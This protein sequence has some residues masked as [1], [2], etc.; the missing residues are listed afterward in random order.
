MT[1]IADYRPD[2]DGLRSL[3]VASVL[4]FHLGLPNFGGGFVGVDIFFVISGFLITG[5]I[6]R[7]YEQTGGFDF[8]RFYVRRVRRIFPALFITIFLATL[9][10]TLLFSSEHLQRLGGSIISAMA[11]TSNLY[12]WSEAG[13]FDA[14][15]FV[16]PLLH[17]WSLSIEEQFYLVWPILLIVLLRVKKS[18]QPVVSIILLAAASLLV[19]EVF[20]DGEVDLVNVLH[21]GLAR[22]I[23]DG[24]STIFYL[25]PFRIYE[26]V[27]GGVLVFI[28]AEFLKNRLLNELIMFAGLII[29]VHSVVTFTESLVYPNYYALWPCAGAAAVIFGGRQSLW[30]KK[31]LANKIAITFGLISYSLYLVHWPV[32]VFWKYY[33]FDD[34]TGSESFIVVIVS[35]ALAF[36]MYRYVE[37][38]LRLK[39]G[40]KCELVPSPSA[41]I[42]ALMV[43][44]GFALIAFSF[45]VHDGWDWRIPPT[46]DQWLAAPDLPEIPVDAVDGNS[47]WTNRVIINESGGAKVLVIGDSH[48]DQLKGAAKYLSKKYDLAFYFFTFTGCPPLFGTYKI[49]DVYQKFESKKQRMCREQ[50]SIWENHVTT[51]DYEYV[52]LSSRW[53]WMFESSDYF[54]TH[55]R[56]DMLVDKENPRFN[57]AASKEV[58]KGSLDYTVKTILTSGAEPIILGQVPNIGKDIEGCNNVPKVFFSAG[59][60]ASRCNHVPRQYV[61]ERTRFSNE[62]IEKTANTNGVF[63]LL[64]TDIFCDDK[65][66]YCRTLERGIRL[67]DDDDHI[68]ERGSVYLARKW[69]RRTDFP[70]RNRP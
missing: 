50:T 30:I 44:L 40:Q 60:I 24:K 65:E 19:N 57:I 21:P 33:K 69:E 22:L 58:F 62:I 6:K 64:P 36:I 35:I 59:N 49:Y 17:T 14:S 29:I 20:A 55:Q 10:S 15:A 13:Y 1:N 68:N 38:P 56:R 5:L 51:K 52:I 26:F 28:S 3:A 39:S 27:A 66:Y 8:R 45:W 9:V 53:N 63:F 18:I 43:L 47:A 37:Q 54:D 46:N 31:I 61:L 23:A 16:K 4:L 25:L 42:V 2:I 32:I 67:K 12:F 34:L 70:F 11:F 41:A 7:E 48:A